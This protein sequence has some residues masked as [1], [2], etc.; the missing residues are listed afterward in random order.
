MSDLRSEEN[1]LRPKYE[2]LSRNTKIADEN[3]SLRKRTSTFRDTLA[4]LFPSRTLPSCEALKPLLVLPEVAYMTFP[5]KNGTAGGG[6]GGPSTS[7]NHLVNNNHS[8][9]PQQSHTSDPCRSSAASSLTHTCA[10]C[11]RTKD[12]HLMAHCD[13]CRKH[14]HIGKRILKDLLDTLFMR[15]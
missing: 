4:A 8:S 14:Y 13:E 3:E 15:F 5:G 1:R 12:Q 2:L 9:H 10:S 7:S 11:Q 6:G